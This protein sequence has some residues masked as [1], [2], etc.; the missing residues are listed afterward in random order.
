MEYQVCREG[1]QAWERKTG[2]RVTVIPAPNSSNERLRLYQQILSGGE[3]D[4][5]IFQI[6]V[7]W[8]GLLPAN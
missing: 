3:S 5:D 1:V 6:D 7:Y 4:I 8:P 2:H